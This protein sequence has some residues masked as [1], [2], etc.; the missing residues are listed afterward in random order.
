M[1]HETDELVLRPVRE[2]AQRGADAVANAE[3]AIEE[4]GGGEHADATGLLAAGQ[5]LQK[6]GKRALGR[7]EPLIIEKAEKLGDGLR[8]LM[9][10]NGMLPGVISEGSTTHLSVY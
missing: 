1:A 6:E 2:V 10:E 3:A 9:I 8:K 4:L 5:A 7:L